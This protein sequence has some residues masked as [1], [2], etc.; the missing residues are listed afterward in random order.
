MHCIAY[1][2]SLVLIAVLTTTKPPYL[3]YHLITVQPLRNT[4]SSSLVTLTRPPTSSSLRITDCSLWYASLW[5][6]LP[7]SLRQPHSTSDSSLSLSTSVISTAC[8]PS[9]SSSITP[10]F[11]SWLKSYLFQIIPTIDSFSLSQDWLHGFLSASG[12]S[13][14]FFLFLVNWTLCG[15]HTDYTTCNGMLIAFTN[16]D[17]FHIFSD[18]EKKDLHDK[19]YTSA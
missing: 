16:D 5:N 1:L 12:T 18:A 3:N 19:I 7:P 11:L 6:Q 17:I 4:R 14:I 10:L 15:K 13:E 8:V 9:L 2:S